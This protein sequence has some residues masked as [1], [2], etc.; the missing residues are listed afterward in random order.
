MSVWVKDSQGL[1][2]GVFSSSKTSEAFIAELKAIPKLQI[3]LI[4]PRHGEQVIEKVNPS[5]L[6][7]FAY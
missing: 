6:K 3:L 7:L 1:E 2:N 5:K 4:K